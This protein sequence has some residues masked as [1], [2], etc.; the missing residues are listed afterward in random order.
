M[1]LKKTLLIAAAITAAMLIVLIIAIFTILSSYDYN[2]L[3]PEISI[4]AKNATGR[5]LAITGDIDIAIGLSPKIILEGVTFQNA[6][7]GS[8]PDMVK[9]KRIEAQA[10]LIPLI[11][12]EIEVKR[13]FV[14][15]PDILIETNKSGKS[16]ISFYSLKQSRGARPEIKDPKIIPGNLSALTFNNLR[17]ENGTLTYRNGKGKKSYAINLDIFSLAA[18]T[19]ESPVKVELSGGYNENRFDFKGKVGPIPGIFK[20]EI[21]WPVDVDGKAFDADIALKGS[22]QEPLAQKGLDIDFKIDIDEKTLESFEAFQDNIPSLKGPIAISGNVKDLASQRYKFSDLLILLAENDLKGDIEISLKGKTPGFKGSLSSEKIDLRTILS[23]EKP[24]K[25]NGKQKTKKAKSKIFTKESLPFDSLKLIDANV[26]L[27]IAKLILPKLVLEKISADIA[28]KKGRLSIKPLKAG[29][30]GGSLNGDLAIRAKGKS[31]TLA[32]SLSIK[33]FDLGKMLKELKITE[34]LSGRFDIGVKVKARGNSSAAI[35]AGLN[36]HTSVVMEDGRINNRYIEI[37]GA[38]LSASLF[39]LFNPVKKKKK[40]T[41]LNCLVSRFDIVNGIAESEVMVF[42]TPRMS[43]IGSGKVNLKTEKLNISLKPAPK[44]GIG[45]SLSFGELAK[46]F[47]LGGTLAKPS[48]AIDP[49]QTALAI[50][51]AVGGIALFGPVGIAAI[52]LS[53]KS[54]DKNP[55]LTAIA[56]AKK[57]KKSAG[58]KNIIKETTKGIGNKIKSLFGN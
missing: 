23:T 53:G 43:V 33:S 47:K 27:K 52:L 6:K 4:A 31:S 45:L 40:F 16:N 37:A 11:F 7:W 32:T 13:F 39:R 9:I 55:C 17:I 20:P 58:K 46:P 24:D 56:E 34:I 10:A 41:K 28:L 18:K 57:G 19:N 36:G 48:L 49:K 15:E 50:G 35:M 1:R 25:K 21:S 42:D 12:R 30:G 3:K 38:D 44:E 22:I 8:R 26:N 5:E 29:I 51:K 14:I 54:G 2:K